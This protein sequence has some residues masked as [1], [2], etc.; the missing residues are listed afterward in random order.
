[1]VCQNFSGRPDILHANTG[2]SVFGSNNGVFIKGFSANLGVGGSESSVDIDLVYDLCTNGNLADISPGY[3]VILT[4]GSFS[5]GGI[6]DKIDYNESESGIGWKIRISD[7]R[8]LL[9]SVGVLV[10]GYICPTFNSETNFINLDNLLQGDSAGAAACSGSYIMPN[11]GNCGAYQYGKRLGGGT[12]FLQ[13]LNALQSKGPALYTPSG[14][15]LYTDLSQLISVVANRASWATFQGTSVSLLDFIT[16]AADAAGVD[17]QVN[18]NGQ[19]INIIPI[20]RYTEFPGLGAFDTLVQQAKNS[21]ILVNHSSGSELTYNT[22]KKLIL[23]NNIHY[24]SESYYA[25]GQV[26][27]Y[28]GDHPDTGVPLTT[29][30]DALNNGAVINGLSLAIALAVYGISIPNTG[31]IKTGEI[32]AA[33]AGY[34]AWMLYCKTDPNSIG[35]YVGQL[36]FGA[37]WNDSVTNYQEAMDKYMGTRNAK[38]KE[39][40]LKHVHGD[41]ENTLTNAKQADVVMRDVVHQ[42]ILNWAGTWYGTQYLCQLTYGPLCAKGYIRYPGIVEGSSENTK[43]S[44]EV[45]DA[46]WVDPGSSTLGIVA[47][48]A[49]ASI[50]ENSDGRMKCFAGVQTAQY[51]PV[52]IHGFTYDYYLNFHKISGDYVGYGNTLYVPAQT[53]GR[54]YAYSGFNSPPW[55]HV[56]IPKLPCLPIP[57]NASI[58]SQQ[59]AKFAGLGNLLPPE[60]QKSEFNMYRNAE[61][62]TMAIGFSIPMKSNMYVYGPWSGKLNSY[63]KTEIS[64]QTELSPWTYG[65]SAAM[66]AVGQSLAQEGLSGQLFSNTGTMSVAIAPQYS[67]GAIVGTLLTVGSVVVQIGP[68]G[69]TSTYNFSNFTRKFGDIARSVSDSMKTSNSIRREMSGRIKDLRHDNLQALTRALRSLGDLN[70]EMSALRDPPAKEGASQSDRASLSTLIMGGYHEQPGVLL[71]GGGGASGSDGGLTPAGRGPFTCEELCEDLPPG[72]FDW[73]NSGVHNDV[74]LSPEIGTYKMD[75]AVHYADAQNYGAYAINS[76]DFVFSPVS[77]RGG[78]Y[79]PGFGDYPYN[80]VNAFQN[81]PRPIM[82]P[83]QTDSGLQT[84]NL[85]IGGFYLNPILSQAILGSWDDRAMG[86]SMGATFLNIAHG[87]DP[88]D[89]EMKDQESAAQQSQDFRFNALK[90]PLVMQAWGY[91]TE[92]KPIPNYADNAQSA[93]RGIFKSAGLWDSFLENWAA[94]PKTWPVGPI[95]LR[96]DRDRG[97]WVS[98]PEE[99][100]VVAQLMEDLAA[101]GS[102]AAVLLNP[103][104]GSGTFYQDHDVY[105]P[106][107]QHITG[108]LGGTRIIVDDFLG[109][110]L[111]GFNIVYAYH[112]GKGKYLVLESSAVNQTPD[113]CLCVCTTPTPTTTPPTTEPTTEPTPTYPTPT[114]PTPTYPTYSNPTPTYPTYTV[115]TYT[116]PTYTV[117]T[118]T[119]P[120]YTVPTYTVPTYTVPTYTYTVPPGTWYCFNIESELTEYDGDPND[121]GQIVATYGSDEGP[122]SFCRNGSPNIDW[123]RWIDADGLMQEGSYPSSGGPF[124]YEDTCLAECGPPPTEPTT[125]IPTT[126]PPTATPTCDACGFFDCFSELNGGG[127]PPDGV[128]GIKDGCVTIYTLTECRPNQNP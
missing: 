115:P 13:A 116:V 107:G 128:I 43:L 123:A 66:S 85:P 81:K 37:A 65:S 94:N 5:F 26:L 9:S 88:A 68:S 41:A 49:L 73:G 60:G 97:C 96:W 74:N 71:Y 15:A 20:D 4:Y 100:I 11:V 30:T 57:Y 124:D 64:Q 98:P 7:P 16:Q 112:Y 46:G 18:L 87:S 42:W 120:T 72:N 27:M 53:T 75:E 44:D 119:V 48:S 91:D 126:Y 84:S 2:N 12:Y 17:I 63:G 6:V 29:T 111:C 70:R 22:S 32:L 101:N 82:P 62:A 92:G 77:L 33:L 45:A 121:G 55:V 117:P 80:K 103:S 76:W 127:Q 114:Y 8:K 69:C 3:A 54:M 83:V 106:Q 105:G 51:Q 110:N 38:H 40:V 39:E 67:L 95:D 52:K 122:S 31:I 21:G 36:A 109:R 108:E 34:K 102:A 59:F 93:S 61:A 19:Y 10:D 28:I 113:D 25:N 58:G 79:L 89:F 86:T 56:T 1:M 78:G 118:Y 47:G 104:S 24:M 50:F 99:R 14:V 125:V 90:G 23:G 35:A